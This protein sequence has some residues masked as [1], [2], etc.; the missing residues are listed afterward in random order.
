MEGA[1]ASWWRMARHLIDELERSRDLYGQLFF[2]RDLESALIKGLILAQPNN[3]SEELR[4]RLEAY[5][6]KA[7]RLGGSEDAELAAIYERA[8]ELLWTSPCDLREATVTLSGYQQAI[9]S[10]AKGAER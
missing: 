7:A 10:R 3:Y 2:T 5:R 8:R 6:A 4:G 1:A 9:T